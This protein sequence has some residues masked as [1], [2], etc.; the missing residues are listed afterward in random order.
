MFDLLARDVE[1]AYF[2]MIVARHVQR[3]GA[4]PAAGLDHA[5]AGFQPGLAAHMFELR[6]LRLREI[7]GRGAVIGAGV[8]HLRVE[9]KPVEVIAEIVVC[10][11]IAPRLGEGIAMGQRYPVQV[12]TTELLPGALIRGAECGGKHLDQIPVHADPAGGKGIAEAEVRAQAGLPQGL[13]RQERDARDSRI[14]RR[15][16]P[17]I[18]ERE[19][20]RWFT[21]GNAIHAQGKPIQRRGVARVTLAGLVRQCRTQAPGEG[22]GGL[23]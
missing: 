1:R 5:H 19:L 20:D 4:P 17:A 6:C 2:D 22:K 14:H 23:A 18:P 21:H 8:N 12:V 10:G 16:V 13:V 3:E 9:P 11:D 15:A 7:H